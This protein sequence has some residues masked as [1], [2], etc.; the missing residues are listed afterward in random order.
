MAYPANMTVGQIRELVENPGMPIRQP[1]TAVL[2]IDTAD[3]DI[4]DASGYI[5]DPS[6][7]N[8]VYINK[9]QTL[10]NGYFTRIALTELNYLWDIPNVLATAPWKNNTLS[11]EFGVL[12]T[13]GN[14]AAQITIS[15]VENFYTPVE[16]A[17]A[18]QI[19]LL[20]MPGVFASAGWTCVYIERFNTFQI[21]DTASDVPFRIVPKN[22]GDADDLCNLMGL[23]IPSKTF[24]YVVE[25]SFAPMH[26]TPYFDV[27]SDQLT[28]KQNVRDNSTS[29]ITG[30]SLLARIY[31]NNEGCVAVRERTTIGTADT[32]II[33]CRPFTLYKQFTIPK[34]IY[35]DTKEFI[36]VIDITL[37]DYK[38]HIL[39]S[40]P[41][42]AIVDPAP[43]RTK[44]G[45]SA[46]MQ[47]TL[48]I[49]ET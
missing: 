15:V 22:K 9:Q 11:L 45:G 1:A 26:Y 14:A 37:R 47:L 21:A 3:S 34:Q 7:P 2:T 18:L 12:G 17:A 13:S 8:Q 20:A 28:K 39:Y 49:T 44:C 36:N 32:N 35:W 42:Q 30:A 25:S 27:I 48:Q 43:Y 4:Y 46:T 41:K 10:I 33:G 19:A 29:T 38:G 16:L 5:I 23:S 31:L 40:R 24:S 6:N